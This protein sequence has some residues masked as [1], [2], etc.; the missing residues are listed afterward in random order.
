MLPNITISDHVNHVDGTD[1][2]QS[3]EYSSYEIMELCLGVGIP[4]LVVIVT[5]VVLAIFHPEKLLELVRIVMQPVRDALQ[6]AMR[7]RSV[8]PNQLN[9]AIQMPAMDAQPVPQG[10]YF[11]EN[12]QILSQSMLIDLMPDP[13]APRV[14]WV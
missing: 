2:S 9:L 3:A 5:L 14:Q 13:P 7:P 8:V 4:S 10:Q 11:I 12:K 1:H 6:R